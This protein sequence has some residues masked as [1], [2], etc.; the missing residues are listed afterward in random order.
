ML[1]KILGPLA[2]YAVLFLLLAKM[3]RGKRSSYRDEFKLM[4]AMLVPMSCY[5]VSYTVLWHFDRLFVRNFMLED[6]G[7]YGAII[8]LGQIPMW[9]MGAVSFVL[10]PLASAEPRPLGESGAKPGSGIQD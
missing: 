5:M 8:T 7:G 10:F 3:F 2:S 9:L 6:S 4:L 1:A